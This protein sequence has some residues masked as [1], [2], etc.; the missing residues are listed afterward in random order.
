MSVFICSANHFNSLQ[1]SIEILKINDKLSGIGSVQTIQ[2]VFSNLKDLNIKSFYD[3]YSSH[4]RDRDL[5]KSIVQSEKDINLKTKIKP[6][7]F[8]GIYKA[9]NC[10]LYQI[11]LDTNKMLGTEL[12]ALKWIKNVQNKISYKIISESAKYD[13]AAWEVN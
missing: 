5:Q 4:Y 3:K 12:D 11:E 7:D 8:Y 2:N 9:I 13:N 6:L 1:K 10:L